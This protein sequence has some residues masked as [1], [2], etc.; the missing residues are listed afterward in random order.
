MHR[1]REGAVGSSGSRQTLTASELV[2]TANGMN[3]W[4]PIVVATSGWLLPGGWLLV[5][6]ALTQ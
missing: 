2:I 6:T 5:F 3:T 1:N 4:P